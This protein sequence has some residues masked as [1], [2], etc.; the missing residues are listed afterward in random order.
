[1]RNGTKVGAA[2]TKESSDVETGVLVEAALQE[3]ASPCCELG[4]TVT[5]GL[6]M[7]A[8]TETLLPIARAGVR[9]RHVSSAA[10]GRAPLCI[11]CASASAVGPD[12][13][14]TEAT[15]GSELIRTLRAFSVGTCAK[16][17]VAAAITPS[18]GPRPIAAA[19]LLERERPDG[20]RVDLPLLGNTPVLSSI[21]RT[22]LRV[23]ILTTRAS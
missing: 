17:R 9:L 18:V 21:R 7:V 12:S 11:G 10:V 19:T 5:I 4:M 16:V 14:G 15:G 2:S 6:E 13:A 22:S 8:F 1:L 3:L 20:R 23:S